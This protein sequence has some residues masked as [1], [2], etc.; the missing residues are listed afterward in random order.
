MDIAT[1]H[2]V[3][4]YPGIPTDCLP[5]LELISAC[6]FAFPICRPGRPSPCSSTVDD[7]KVNIDVMGWQ[8][9]FWLLEHDTSVRTR[10]C[11][12]TNAS[13]SEHSLTR[14]TRDAEDFTLFLDRPCSSC[15]SVPANGRTRYMITTHSML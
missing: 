12:L 8:D 3:P 15:G 2:I 1:D 7:W 11:L 5:A 4:A 9:W 6:E 13:L 14:I 10:E